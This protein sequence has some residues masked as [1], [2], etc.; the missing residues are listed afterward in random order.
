[1]RVL[2]GDEKPDHVL[3][4]PG[5]LVRRNACRALVRRHLPQQ[6]GDLDA[7]HQDA[8]RRMGL[9]AVVPVPDLSGAEAVPGP[10]LTIRESRHLE[11]RRI[12]AFVTVHWAKGG[13]VLDGGGVER[14]EQRAGRELVVLGASL[15]S[16]G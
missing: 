8:E 1:M 10:D 15:A 7:V 13:R 6:P 14:G 2:V 11:H 9:G 12:E 4:A 16:E 5:D 3:Q